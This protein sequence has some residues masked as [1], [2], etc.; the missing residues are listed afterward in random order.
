MNGSQTPR[1]DEIQAALDEGDVDRVRRVL[2]EVEGRERRLLAEEL[3]P[4]AFGRARSAASRGG[5]RGKLGR[6]LVLP[7]IMGSELDSVDAKGDADRIWLNYL[8]LI[9]GRIGDLELAA[10][11]SPALPGL[12]V[13]PAGVHRKTYLSM[14]LELDTRWD[15]RPFP[16]DWRED[17]D[18]SADRLAAEVRAFGG[19]GPSTWWHIPWGDSSRADSS[20]V[21]RTS[22]ARWTIRAGKAVVAA[23]SCWGP[24]IAARSRSRSP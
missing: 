14:I 23:S 16:F 18:K 4:E 7:G 12:H 19:G 9:R 22:G 2:L 10:D 15:V 5:R 3:G 20:S 6:V 24:R 13:R 1:L 21:T 17:I 11:G 8:R